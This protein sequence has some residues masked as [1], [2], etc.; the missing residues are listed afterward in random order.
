M[1]TTSSPA[2]GSPVSGS[3]RARVSGHRPSNSS[4]RPAPRIRHGGGFDALGME[5]AERRVPLRAMGGHSPGIARQSSGRLPPLT[6]GGR[7]RGLRPGFPRWVGRWPRS[8]LTPDSRF[9]AV[10]GQNPKVSAPF[11]GKAAPEGCRKSTASGAGFGFLEAVPCNADLSCGCGRGSHLHP[12]PRV[13]LDPGNVPGWDAMPSGLGS[14]SRGGACPYAAMGSGPGMRSPARPS[15]PASRQPGRKLAPS[16][17]WSRANRPANMPLGDGALRRGGGT[18]PAPEPGPV[19]TR[20]ASAAPAVS[21]GPETVRPFP[22]LVRLP[23]PSGPPP[24]ELSP[25]CRR[26]PPV[27]VSRVDGRA[28]SAFEGAPRRPNFFL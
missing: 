1:R 20:A 23:L 16:L 4:T 21:T 17:L 19:T 10:P 26:P 27:E 6:G 3:T 12:S 8:C 28:L 11:T 13:G 2:S 5:A 18:G 7:G 9:W 15:S 14:K 24:P 25:S 22:L